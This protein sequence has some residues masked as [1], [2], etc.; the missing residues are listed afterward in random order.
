MAWGLRA[1]AQGSGDWG[2]VGKACH[3]SEA[4]TSHHKV[5]MIIVPSHVVRLITT[6]VG[7]S[8]SLEPH[9]IVPMPHL[10]YFPWQFV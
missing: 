10:A 3:L 6:G 1:L 4:Q 7:Y 8:L 5:G 2:A 9:C